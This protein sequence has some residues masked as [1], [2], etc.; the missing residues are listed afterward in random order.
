MPVIDPCCHGLS[1]ENFGA[2]EQSEEQR[3][4]S[5]VRT[6][7]AALLTYTL[8]LVNGDAGRAE[9]V[10]QETFVRAWRQIDRLTRE[11]GSVTG[12]LR[13][14]AYNVAID[15]HRMRRARPEEVEL[16]PAD[17]AL[18]EDVDHADGVLMEIT[19]RQL[20]ES[21]WPEHRAVLVEVYL[22]DR[23][24]SQAAEVLGIPVGTVKSRLHYALRTL[25]ETMDE[26]PAWAS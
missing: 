4:I 23:T 19:V 25:R 20:L 21:V 9:D 1:M 18:R 16:G 24:A 13:R 6:H 2:D 7:R 11:H 14:V 3:F 17:V 8:R 12:W 22:H 5:I 10:V 26:T 15:G